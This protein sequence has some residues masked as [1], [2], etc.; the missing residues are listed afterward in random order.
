M[1][2]QSNL[3]LFALVAKQHGLFTTNSDIAQALDPLNLELQG[4][5]WF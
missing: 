5:K 3:W 2:L 1:I 4:I